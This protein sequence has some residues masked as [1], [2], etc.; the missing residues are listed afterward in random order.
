MSFLGN[1]VQ[2]FSEAEQKE[3]AKFLEGENARARIQQSVHSITDTV[4][5]IAL[6]PLYVITTT[7]LEV[8]THP[9]CAVLGKVH[10]KDQQQDRQV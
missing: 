9:S 7:P 4:S 6:K 8:H 3:L 2:E 5:A 1:D 10:H